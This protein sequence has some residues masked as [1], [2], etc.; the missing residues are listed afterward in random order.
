[1]GRDPVF[2]L[3]AKTARVQVTIPGNS[4][5]NIEQLVGNDYRDIALWANPKIGVGQTGEGNVAG[6]LDRSLT[7]IDLIGTTQSIAELV[8]SRGPN[9]NLIPDQKYLYG[10][11]TKEFVEIFNVSPTSTLSASVSVRDMS[12]PFA[13]SEKLTLLSTDANGNF[14]GTSSTGDYAVVNTYYDDSSLQVNQLDWRTTHKLLVD[15]GSDGQYD[16][17]SLDGGATGGSGSHGIITAVNNT[18][19]EDASAGAAG[20]RIVLLTDVSNVSGSTL[21]FIPNETLTYMVGD[22]PVQGTIERVEGPELDLFSGE[23][24]YIKGLTQEISRVVEQTDVFRFTF[25][26]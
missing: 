13:R 8:D 21:G 23:L 6:Y 16:P 11:S 10:A 3:F 2:E 24:L 12:K 5:S 20:K 7:R 25:E 19:P 14:T 18:D 4:D 22:N 15:F 17:I 1:V 9:G 26:F